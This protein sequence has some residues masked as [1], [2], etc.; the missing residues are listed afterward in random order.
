MLN[1][2]MNS[3]LKHE[4]AAESRSQ[5]SRHLYILLQPTPP[6]EKP[7]VEDKLGVEKPGELDWYIFENRIRTII[8]QLVEPYAI[9]I[10][11]GTDTA[12]AV[13]KDHEKIKRRLDEL[14]FILNKSHQRAAGMEDLHRQI[15]DMV[16]TY[17]AQLEFFSSQDNDRRMQELK[18]KQDNEVIWTHL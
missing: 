8:H 6:L 14:E 13:K 7:E 15:R 16:K 17:F 3:D 4:E 10:I 5:V 2:K 1:L 12:N 18:L 9:K 11:H